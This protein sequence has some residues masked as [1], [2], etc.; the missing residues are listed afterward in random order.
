MNKN[1]KIALFTDCFYPGNGGTENVI[2]TLVPL[3]KGLGDTVRIYA[4][5]YHIKNVNQSLDGFDVFRVPSLRLSDNDNIAFVSL[6]KKKLENDLVNFSPDI[7]YFLTA[8]PMAKWAVKF[9]KK[10]NL[11]LVATLHT[12]F[13]LA[14]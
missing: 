4:P 11:P 8:G 9:A 14:W 7:I 5:N 6:V 10:L 1:I 2:R 12:K 13:K 3:L